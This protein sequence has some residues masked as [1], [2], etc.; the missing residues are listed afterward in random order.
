MKGQDMKKR[1]GGRGRIARRVYGRTERKRRLTHNTEE[2]TE[3]GEK[4]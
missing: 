4:H 3:I 1:Q 2:D